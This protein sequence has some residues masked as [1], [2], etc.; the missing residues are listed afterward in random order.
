MSLQMIRAGKYPF[1]SPSVLNMQPATQ[2]FSKI[3]I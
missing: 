2:I 1:L 3:L